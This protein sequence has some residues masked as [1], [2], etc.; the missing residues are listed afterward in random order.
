MRRTAHGAEVE[1][2]LSSH[3]MASDMRNMGQSMEIIVDAQDWE[4]FRRVSQET[5]AAWL[6]DQARRVSLQRYAKAPP[7]KKPARPPAKRK[8]DPEK[9]HVSL[10]RLLVAE[11]AAAAH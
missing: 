7:R 9:T 11:R 2:A 8:H 10:A 3:A 5:M 4:V 6:L 1:Q